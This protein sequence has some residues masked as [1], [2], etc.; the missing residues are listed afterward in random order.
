MEY[1]WN[2]HGILFQSPPTRSFFSTTPPVAQ[3]P[4]SPKMP[5]PGQWIVQILHR[6]ILQFLTAVT[7]PL[8]NDMILIWN[9]QPDRTRFMVL[10]KHAKLVQKRTS[11]RFPHRFPWVSWFSCQLWDRPISISPSVPQFNGWNGGIRSRI[12]HQTYLRIW[13]ISENSPICSATSATQNHCKTHLIS[14]QETL[15]AGDA[16]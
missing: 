15:M 16:K 7:Y 9:Q 4:V 14:G 11:K 6:L 12:H 1:A 8:M 2:I 5:P 3:S 10:A 13:K